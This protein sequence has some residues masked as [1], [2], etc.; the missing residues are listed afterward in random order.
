[1]R[2]LPS[3]LLAL[4]FA[5]CSSSREPA[6]TTD[7][8]PTVADADVSCGAAPPPC[9]ATRAGCCD[10]A[11]M[12]TCVDGSFVCPEGASPGTESDV[13]A[14]MTSCPDVTCGE[15]TCG[16]GEYCV[17]PCCGG[18]LPPCIDPEPDGSCPPGTSEGT[19]SD[20]GGS[21]TMGCTYTCEPP[22]PYCAPATGCDAETC[23]PAGDACSGGYFDAAT[24]T[25]SCAC[26]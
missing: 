3:L 1:M 26:A 5:A 10:V 25:Y 24:R 16:A 21:F 7:G 4:V 20:G 17:V 18:A 11:G 22:P 13:A 9:I 12:A 15:T 23:P 19:C 6:P 8:G 14:C 2:L